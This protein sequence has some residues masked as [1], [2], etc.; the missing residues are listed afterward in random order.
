M[1]VVTDIFSCRTPRVS[2]YFRGTHADG[3]P[4]DDWFNGTSMSVV[5]DIF[6]CRTPR[7]SRYFRGT[8][9]D[10]TPYDDWFNGTVA[11]F[12]SQQGLY[13]IRY[14]DGDMEELNMLEALEA[15]AYY[16]YPEMT[17]PNVGG[18]RGGHEHGPSNSRQAPAART[19]TPGRVKSNYDNQIESLGGRRLVQKR[20]S[21]FTPTTDQDDSEEERMCQ[22]PPGYENDSGDVEKVAANDEGWN[23]AATRDG[24]ESRRGTKRS[25]D[26]ETPPRRIDLSNGWIRFRTEVNQD[27]LPQNLQDVLHLMD[28]LFPGHAYHRKLWT[29]AAIGNGRPGVETRDTLR[30]LQRLGN[31][32]MAWHLTQRSYAPQTKE[33]LESFIRILL[34]L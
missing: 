29:K 1:S 26:F 11:S 25:G 22:P 5:T 20:I 28:E 32:G 3:T 9:A 10:G 4:Y 2:R 19:V 23:V 24:D 34:D 14:D 30:L 8:H 17:R 21:D 6:S 7:V 33:D 31:P 16:Y 13:L 15:V 18:S 27:N 12:N